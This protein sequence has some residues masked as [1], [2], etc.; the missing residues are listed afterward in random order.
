VTYPEFP[1]SQLVYD[2]DVKAVSA[3]EWSTTLSVNGTYDGPTDVVGVRD[4]EIQWTSDG[5]TLTER[6]RASLVLASG[7]TIQSQ[8]SSSIVT[9][10]QGLRA[11]PAGG[12]VVRVDISPLKVDGKTMSYSW[13]G[14]VRRS[15]R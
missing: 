12:E 11:F 13:E 5:K 2:A 7:R 3:T 14:T 15:G 4:Y 9:G 1:K 8:W 10:E 6:G